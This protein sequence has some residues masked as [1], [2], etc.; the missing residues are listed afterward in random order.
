[1]PKVIMQNPSTGRYIQ[2][3]DW[4]GGLP[5]R[6]VGVTVDPASHSGKKGQNVVNVNFPNGEGAT[7]EY[8]RLQADARA[9]GYV[10][11]TTGTSTGA[12]GNRRKAGEF[13]FAAVEPAKAETTDKPKA[14]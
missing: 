8:E 10:Q 11:V 14:K 12:S 7:A 4:P 13:T 1:M 5:A 6:N 2:I 3:H 9:K